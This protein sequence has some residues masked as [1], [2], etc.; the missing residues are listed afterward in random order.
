ME[1]P[2]EEPGTFEPYEEVWVRYRKHYMELFE[3]VAGEWRSN[4]RDYLCGE[5]QGHLIP[6]SGSDAIAKSILYLYDSILHDSESAFPLLKTFSSARRN[7]L[8]PVLRAPYQMAHRLGHG[9]GRFPLADR[10]RDVLAHLA[11][12]EEGEIIAVN[13]PPGTGKTAMILSAV[14]GEWVRAARAAG[15]PPVIVA[16]SSNNQAIKNIL[17]AFAGGFD[18]GV[19]NHCFLGRW[20]PDLTN[21]GLYF[22]AKSKEEDARKEYLT[23]RQFS[24]SYENREYV[25]RAMSA[26]LDAAKSALPELED[27]TLD[28]VVAALH[29][30][31]ETEVR[32]LEEF[33]TTGRSLADARETIKIV[34]DTEPDGAIEALEECRRNRVRAMDDNQARQSILGQW[35]DYLGREPLLTALFS[36]LP[37]VRQRRLARARSFLRKIGWETDVDAVRSIAAVTADMRGRKER[38]SRRLEVT[39]KS[40]TRGKKAVKRFASLKS[41]AEEMIRDLESYV[42]P[43]RDPIEPEQT[44]DRGIRF[45]LFRLTTHYWEGRWLQEMH[46]LLP[47][48]GK[49]FDDSDEDKVKRKWRIRM[50]LTPCMVATFFTLPKPM[51][52]NKSQLMTYWKDDHQQY[53]Y[54]FIDLLVVDEAG[55]TLPEAAGASFALAKKALV[56]GDTCQIEPISNLPVAVDIGNLNRSGILGKDHTDKELEHVSGLGIRSVGGSALKVAQ[57][58]CRYH[59]EAA[60]DRG[61]YLFQH[62]RCWNEIISY[63]NKKFYGSRL[64]PARGSS[65]NRDSKRPRDGLRPFSWLHVDGYC[66]SSGGSRFNLAEA[67][68][69]ASWLAKYKHALERQ[70]RNGEKENVRLEEIVAVLTPFGRQAHEIREA[71]GAKHINVKPGGM[72]V[73]TIHSLQG[74]ERP[75]VIFSPAYSIHAP[76]NFIENS[77]SMLNVAVSRA[78][79]SFL[80]FGDMGFFSNADT[81]TPREVLSRYLFGHPDNELEFKVLPRD[82]LVPP[83]HPSN[84]R[85]EWNG[86]GSDPF[87]GSLKNAKEHDEW[88]LE[89]LARDDIGKIRIVSPWIVVR[90]I[91]QAGILSALQDARNRGKEISVFVDPELNGKITSRGTSNLQQAEE[92]FSG[93]GVNLFKVRKL[94]SK[95]VMADDVVLVL[96]SYNWLSAPREGDLARHETSYVVYEG[97]NRVREEIGRITNSLMQSAINCNK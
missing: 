97:T 30:R 44:A 94:H 58:A 80:V 53:L 32:K 83:V 49:E 36:F 8:S 41:K 70:Y 54:N 45:E 16:A 37:P 63:C 40:L 28:C 43:E 52:K 5:Q 56:I 85:Q 42:E 86:S 76:G 87:T 39:E 24:A 66:E 2:F 17:D 93:I 26:Y 34:L 84:P 90:T 50:M 48:I 12:A 31:I 1:S 62:R 35:D 73:G 21:Y 3:R 92:A 71:C 33:D 89:L 81:G 78:R 19:D 13:G 14:A 7:P 22:P 77:S 15:E 25:E 46:R 9:T 88:L 91:E 65:P 18:D 27:A 20:L 51:P 4:D 59:A 47:D 72:T 10:Q 23:E 67:R 79:D 60:M 74:S 29:Q 95:I 75:V 55:Q 69:I 6:S 64:L 82:D 11:V 68:T 38:C 57:S 96:G 61:F